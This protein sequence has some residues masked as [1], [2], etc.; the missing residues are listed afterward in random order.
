VNPARRIAILILLGV[1]ILVLAIIVQA[2]ARDYQERLLAVI[3]VLGGL[4]V[5][6]VSLPTSNG[7]RPD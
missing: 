1:G 7:K 2:A 4:A 6:V 5:V 3:G